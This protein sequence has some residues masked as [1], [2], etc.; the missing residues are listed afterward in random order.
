MKKICHI[1]G[2]GKVGQ[3]FAWLL[4][5]QEG[6]QLSHIVSSK[7]PKNAFGAEILADIA[8]L[9]PANVMII[10]TP[11]NAIEAV[12]EKMAQN[13]AVDSQT[14]VLHLSGAKT[15][16]ALAAVRQRGAMV[17]SLHPVFAFA[18]VAHAAAHLR[19]HV[20]ALEAE[21]PQALAVLQQLAEA[22]GLQAFVL[23]SEYKARYHAALSAASNFS[24]ALAAYAQNLLAPL[25]LP[26]ALSRQLVCG[27]LQQSVD[28]LEH[29]P[30]VQALTG[31]IV[32]GDDRTVAAHLSALNAAEQ[33]RYHGWALATLDLAAARLSAEAVAKM[34]TVL[35]QS[36][37]AADEPAVSAQPKQ[38]V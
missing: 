35:A 31:P 2:A 17:G 36:L 25:D 5:E 13:T 24:V 38:A 21:Q 29:L 20:C 10:A 30:P 33:V 19:G 27:L 18:D 8:D 16:A 6:W 26:E 4:S 23:P 15:T 32:R 3:T 22:L 14:L 7:L 11:D 9:P 12:A 34:Q 37:E 1:I 28:N